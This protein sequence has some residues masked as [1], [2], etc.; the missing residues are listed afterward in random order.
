MITREGQIV[1]KGFNRREGEN[2]PLAH[3]EILAIQEA[4]RRIGHWRLVG[5]TIYVT[6]EPCAM[7]AGAL[8]NR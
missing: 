8:I 3:A 7:C 1:G 6:L 5:S 2:D 4:A